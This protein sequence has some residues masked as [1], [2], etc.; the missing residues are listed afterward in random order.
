MS[1]TLP[2]DIARASLRA[3]LSRLEPVDCDCPLDLR[4]P[5]GESCDPGDD[6]P[7]C[8]GECD[9]LPAEYQPPCCHAS[10][11]S[12]ADTIRAEQWF[13]GLWPD[14]AGE[15]FLC[16]LAA[17]HR[18]ANREE[19]AEPPA[20]LPDTE[21]ADSEAYILL[22]ESRASAGLGLRH[23]LDFSRRRTS[24]L[25]VPLETLRNGVKVEKEPC[26]G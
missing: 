21:C 1:A 3:L 26:H 20:P 14:R 5:C 24:S 17:L 12:I 15:S 8:R 2:R 19:Y 25:A 16:K 23:P 6:C 4:C 22:M 7:H 9:C 11:P 10:Q 18:Y 13:A